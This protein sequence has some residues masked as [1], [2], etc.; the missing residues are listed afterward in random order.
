[1]CAQLRDWWN[2][3]GAFGD[4]GNAVRRNGIRTIGAAAVVCGIGAAAIA[5]MARWNGHP[6]PYHLEV[7]FLAVGFVG[8]ALVVVGSLRTRDDGDYYETLGIPFGADRASIEAAFQ[9]HMISCD[10]APRSQ[11]T[12][13]RRLALIEAHD[14]LAD[15]G[16]RAEYDQTRLRIRQDRHDQ[17]RVRDGRY[18][19][20]ETWVDNPGTY[21]CVGAMAV[22]FVASMGLLLWAAASSLR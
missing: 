2:R 14:V 8:V 20:R 16:R 3:W 19:G 6:A 5:R 15:P 7:I 21:G 13:T 4:V 22:G 18:F 9:A 1:M 12:A 11:A 10:A 17:A